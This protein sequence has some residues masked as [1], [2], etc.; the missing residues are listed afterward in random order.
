MKLRNYLDIFNNIQKYNIPK[1]AFNG[2]YLKE[3]GMKEGAV[4][5]KTLKLIES[6]WVDNDFRISNERVQEII[7][8]QIS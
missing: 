1:F 6:E 8:S 4:I 7:Q 5:G 3:K 2:D